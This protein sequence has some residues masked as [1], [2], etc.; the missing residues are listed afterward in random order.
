MFR[1]LVPSRF[2]APALTPSGADGGVRLPYVIQI[3]SA[4]P[5]WIQTWKLC[6]SVV[7]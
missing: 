4:A 3:P 7:P 6:F 5:S 2:S 1:P